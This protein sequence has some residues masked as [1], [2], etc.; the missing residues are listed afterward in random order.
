MIAAYSDFER[1]GTVSPF[2]VVPLAAAAGADVVMVDT[3]K[4]DG[5]S[6]FEF[7]DEAEL[8]RFVAA[9][10]AAGLGVALA[11]SLVFD[12]LDALRRIGPDIIGVRGMV[13]GGDRN[14]MLKEDLVHA[15]MAAI[16]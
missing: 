4:K 15:A 14:A 9:G 1:L 13:C 7:M 3:G 16:R 8:S 10:H 5:R 12:D 6:T 11:G 2:D